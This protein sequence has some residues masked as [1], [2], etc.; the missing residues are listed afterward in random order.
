MIAQHGSIPPLPGCWRKNNIAIGIFPCDVHNMIQGGDVMVLPWGVSRLAKKGEF[1]LCKQRLRLTAIPHFYYRS[2]SP[3]RCRFVIHAWT[4]IFHLSGRNQHG[5]GALL[6]KICKIQFSMPSQNK[7]TTTQQPTTWMI[8]SKVS[9]KAPTSGLGHHLSFPAWCTSLHI[10]GDAGYARFAFY[11]C[12]GSLGCQKGDPLKISKREG[13]DMGLW[14]PHLMGGHNNQPKV[15]I[16]SGVHV[17]C[18][19]GQACGWGM[20]PLFW[21]GGN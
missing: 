14:W 5:L 17:E 21:G 16:H 15:S 11:H 6:Y 13:W 9:T 12:G 3:C 18:W 10:T 8:S 1:S 2:H 20:S 7:T 4:I 19:G